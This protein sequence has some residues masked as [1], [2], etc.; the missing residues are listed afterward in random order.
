VSD[1]RGRIVL[2]TGAP[3]GAG[4][5]ITQRFAMAGA[6]V[7]VNF[8]RDLAGAKRL[9]DELRSAGGRAVLLPGDAADPAQAW[10]MVE[11][12]DLQWGPLDLVVEQSGSEDR[13][14]AERWP[15]SLRAVAAVEIARAALPSLSHSPIGRIVLLG[16]ATPQ[17]PAVLECVRAHVD[18]V[19]TCA[20]AVAPGTPVDVAAVAVYRLAL[21]E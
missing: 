5:R 12:L 10:A 14:G 4:W 21:G 15:P 18:P 17:L 13:S 8:R 7:G 9:V 3:A 19:A 2:V 1:L 11:R 20:L 6:W 16:P